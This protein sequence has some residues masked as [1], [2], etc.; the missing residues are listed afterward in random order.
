MHSWYDTEQWW[1]CCHPLLLCY[2]SLPLNQLLCGVAGWLVVL[3]GKHPLNE[4]GQHEVPQL[5]YEQGHEYLSKS[6]KIYIIVQ[7]ERF[8]WIGDRLFR[9][10]RLCVS[11]STTSTFWSIKVLPSDSTWL[12]L[13]VALIKFGISCESWSIKLIRNDN[14]PSIAHTQLILQ[15]SLQAWCNL[16]RGQ[17]MTCLEMS[18]HSHHQYQ[19]HRNPFCSA[20]R[21]TDVKL[22]VEV[23]IAR[24]LGSWNIV[25]TV[26]QLAYIPAMMHSPRHW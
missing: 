4:T 12:T 23:W 25:F 2:L 5:W 6:S 15:E 10:H 8:T 19:I 14:I 22:I 18:H 26:S 16:C 24:S 9:C 1:R 20:V 21:L 11:A 7:L 13:S 3:T 17:P